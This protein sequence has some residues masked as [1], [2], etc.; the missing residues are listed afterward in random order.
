MTLVTL[1]ASPSTLC[2]S[3]A[4]IPLRLQPS[5]ATNVYKHP[6]ALK[7]GEGSSYRTMTISLASRPSS[8]VLFS[9]ASHPVLYQPNCIHSF[10][11]HTPFLSLHISLVDSITLARAASAS[12][13]HPQLREACQKSV[14]I[15]F[16]A[17]D[18]INT[19]PYR[20]SSGRVAITF[21][22]YR[23]PPRRAERSR[24]SEAA[25]GSYCLSV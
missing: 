11:T 2:P 22:C 7:E 4:D 23:P 9:R 15:P 10:H 3:M 13:C 14:K 12:S 18:N 17:I 16:C 8:V 21:P 19:A 6:P 5:L 24:S 20:L 25:L 1:T